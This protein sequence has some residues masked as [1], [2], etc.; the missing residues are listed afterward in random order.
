M[1]DTTSSDRVRITIDGRATTAA[2][3]ATILNAARQM[4]VSIPTLCHYRGLSPYGACRICLVEIDT[5]R[6]P[7]QVASCSYPV[8]D[9]LVVRTGT[10]AVR[11]SRRTVLELLLAEAPQSQELAQLAAELGVSST[12]LEKAA[13]GKCILCGLCVRTCN[14]LMARGAISMFGRGGKRRVSTA[15]QESSDQCQACGACVFVCPTGA[16]DLATISARR[17]KLHQTRYAQFLE[18]RPSIDLAHPQASPRVPVIDR[19][20]CVHFTTGECGLCAKVCQAGAIDYDQPV[21]KLELEVGSVV[22]TPGFEAFDAARRGEFGYGLAPNVLTSVQFERMLSASGPTHG[23][24]RRPADGKAPRR[25]AFIQCV[26]SRD[27]GCDN[28]YCSSICCMAATKEAILAKEHEPGLDVTIFFLDLRAFGKDFDRYCDR[29]KNQLGVRY[30][31]SFISRVYEMPGTRNLRLVH[32]DSEGAAYP[33][34]QVEEEFDMVVLSLGLEPSASLQEQA[35]RLGVL[36]NRWGF[37][38]TDEFRP[39]DTSR[40]G[41]FVGGAFQEPKDIPD[42]VMQASAAA[43][44]AMTLLA[45][46]RGSRVKTRAYPPERDISDE[47]PR[48]GV[49]VCHCGSN[50][51]A[52]VDVERVV[53][54]TRQLPGVV[55]AETNVYTCADDNQDL[56]KIKIAEHR[57]NRVVVASCTPRTHEP[58][59]RDTLRA[60][61]LNPYLLEMANIR[62]QCSWVHSGNPSAATDKAIDLVRMATARAANL[63][64]LQEASAPVN[65]AALVVGGGIAGMTAALALAEQGFP[66]HLVE[67]SDCLGGTSRQIHRTLEGHDVQSLLAETIQRTLT[68]PRITVY[69]QSRVAK[70]GGHV[71]EFSSQIANGQAASDVLCGSP[72][73]THVRRGSPDPA[74]VWHGSPDPAEARDR[75]VSS[76]LGRPSVD[77][78]ARSG[79]RPQQTSEI[80]H[81]VVVVAT[82]ATE[83]KPATYNYGKSE[84]VMTQ[85][86][87]SDRLGQDQIA[88]PRPGVPGAPATVAMI[89]CVEQSRCAAAVLQPR[90]LHDGGQECPG[91]ETPLA[92]CP[93]R[94][95]LPRHAD[96]RVPR[97]GLSRGAGERRAVYPLRTRATAAVVRRRREIASAGTGALAG[98]RPGFG[99]GPRR[100][101]RAGRAAGRSRR[102][103]RVVAGAVERRRV[104]PRSAHE[105]PPGR[106][107]QRGLVPLR[108][109]PR[110]EIHQRDD[111]PGHRGGGPGRVDPLAEEDAGWRPDRLGRSGPVHLLHDLCAHLPLHG[112]SGRREQ[113]GRGARGRVHGLRELLGRLSGQGHYAAAL[114]GRPDLG[115]G[116]QPAGSGSRE[117]AAS[118]RLSGRGRRGPTEVE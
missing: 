22:L 24:V 105:A 96:L 93:D 80:H 19:D 89:Q 20:N 85:L 109:G 65:N 66:V 86:E 29:A 107:C 51:A 92:G 87:L 52:V 83:Q 94:G 113:Q 67:K 44:R 54:R 40:P 111:L 74:H 103:V 58:I 56:M 69:L 78:V 21:E 10:E 95:L 57:L 104:L 76:P 11:E 8:E 37:A 71:G 25:L 14:D 28:A 39:L 43:A 49:F 47:P 75:Q 7:R 31:R 1:T 16:V 60:S 61:G 38:A 77:N 48:I 41:V 12:P 73:P 91:V 82:G 15:F 72:D 64:P 36:L 30:V 90:L 97:G 6:G 18:S 114:H 55:L 116:Q 32:A 46:A 50:I 59:F 108:S 88:L 45:P 63:V 110:A 33:M 23:H 62:D 106:F 9:G 5:L 84:R 68:H 35:Q 102:V 98:P 2:A 26:G 112:P 17:P 13:E 70:V 53:Q 4:G 115:G 101:G 3:D 79:E 118:A 27:H 100:P 81:G 99:A 42:T 34:K 117:T